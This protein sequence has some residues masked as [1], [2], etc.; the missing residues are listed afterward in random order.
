MSRL[1]GR[2]LAV[3]MAAAV[4]LPPAAAPAADTGARI[5]AVDPARGRWLLEG[6]APFYFGNPG[7]TPFL[8]DWDCDGIDTPGLYRAEDGYVYLANASRSQVADVAFFFGDPGDVPLAGDFDGD[9]CDTVAVYRPAEGRVFI[10]NRL[11]AGD[12]GLGSADHE[13]FF[14]DPADEPFAGDF[15]G[16]GV[17]TIGLFRR[18]TGRVYLRNDHQE[19]AATETFIFGDPGDRPVAGDWDGDGVDTIGVF[20]P[21]DGRF[22]LRNTNRAGTADAVVARGDTS[23]LPVAG[24]FTG[25]GASC[26]IFPPDN[27]WNTD[28]SGLAVHPNSDAYIDAIG[29]DDTLHPDFGT[30]YQGR[31]IGIPYVV[32]SDGQ[33]RVPVVFEYADESD[34]GPYPIPPDVPIEGGPG[35]D[36]DR[37]VIVLDNANCVLYELFDAHPQ[38][39]GSWQAGSGAIFDLTSNR[40]R[41]DYWTSADAAGLPILPGLVRYDE[42]VEEGLV[43][44]A[45]RFTVARTRRAFIHPATHFAS[46]NTATDLPPMGLRLRMKAGYDCSGF[47]AE[48]QVICDA[49]K[50]YGMFVADNGSDWFISG[51][52]DPR[53]DDDDLSDL[54]RIAGAAFEVVDTGEPII[55]E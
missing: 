43:G 15:D 53:W 35:S 17:D 9:G 34:P 50:R 30:E 23:S 49:L 44:H 45:L 42:V 33:P 8:G 51:A 27:P 6:V 13:Y 54:K 7:D 22:Y 21:G 39:D 18:S 37:H 11:G 40:L 55:T 5:G 52:P 25:G 20:R 47:S 28:V 29:R 19:G 24:H 10:V 4:L 16:D 1:V 36:G 14:G 31:P 38:P 41:P 32:V 46:A 3:A 26:A 48:V 12:A 2:S